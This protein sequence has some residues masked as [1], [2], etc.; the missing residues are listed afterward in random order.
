MVILGVLVV[1]EGGPMITLD[2]LFSEPTDGMTA[3]GVFPALVGTVWLVTVALLA[4][5]PVGVAAALYPE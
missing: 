2:F 3:G 4:S 1:Y 5:V